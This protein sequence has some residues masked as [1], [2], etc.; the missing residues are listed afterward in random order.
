MIACVGT[1]AILLILYLISS[2]SAQIPIEFL[3]D[4]LAALS[5]N[6]KV[7]DFAYEIFDVTH[8]V[9]F[10]SVAGFFVFLSVQSVNKR[11]WN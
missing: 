5:L 11:R 2:F 6:D 7:I 9:Y 10:L 8:I 4:F 3:A 1:F